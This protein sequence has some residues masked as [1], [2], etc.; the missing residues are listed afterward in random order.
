MPFEATAADPEKLHSKKPSF[1]RT[2]GR[3]ASTEVASI[4]WSQKTMQSL[5]SG[6]KE[7]PA[8]TCVPS[9]FGMLRLAGSC[10]LMRM[11]DPAQQPPRSS[12]AP[13][14]L[15]SSFSTLA[16]ATHNTLVPLQ[17]LYRIRT[18]L[19]VV[20]ICPYWPH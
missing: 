8:R 2:T 17:F 20:I 5:R 11:P 4:L 6:K 12:S 19:S 3:T 16:G 9:I 1:K 7:R 18:A 10:P 13:R 14:S 15:S